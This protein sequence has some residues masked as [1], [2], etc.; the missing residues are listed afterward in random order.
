MT[1]L[2]E[3]W[4]PC[5]EVSATSDKGWGSGNSEVMLFS[6][7]AKRPLAQA[8]AAV[9]T[10]LLPWPEEPSEQRRLQNL[11][12][13]S[14]EG[15]DSAEPA[16]LAEIER[17]YP[18]G[19]SLL[20]PFS[21]RGMIPLEGA[22]LGLQAWG[23]DYLPVA[24][25]A[26]RL[27][28]D[29]PMRDWRLEPDLP[30]LG[31]ERNPL[32][33]RLP[34]D[35]AAFLSE[36]QRSAYEAL[37]FVYPEVDGQR[38][39][40]YLWATAIPCQEC[41]HSFPLVGS[42]MLRRPFPK[43]SDAGQSLHFSGDPDSGELL[44]EIRSGEPTTQPTRVVAHGKS[45]Y[46]SAGKVAVCSHCG[47]V[48][49]KEVHTRL[50][51]DGHG[52]E[53]LL[54][55]ADNDPV[56]QRIFRL[57]SAVDLSGVAL[58]H[59]QLFSLPPVQPS[60]PAVPDEVIPPANTWTIQ[61]Q[62]FGAKT[63]GDLCPPRQNLSSAALTG[64]I[65][66]LARDCLDAGV[67]L[68]YSRALAEYACAVLA[69]RLKFSTRGARLRTPAGGVN[70]SDVFGN[71]ESSWSY[72]YDY[73][74][75]GLADG[76]GTWQSLAKDTV[77]VLKRQFQRAAG[78][79]ATILRGSACSLPF[80][81]ARMHAVVTDPPY[82]AMIDYADASDLYFVWMKR[83]LVDL[84]PEFT[85]TTDPRGLQDKA[86]EMIVKKGNPEG[87]HRTPQ[88]Y[89][90]LITRAFAEARRVVADD[91][92]VTIVFGHG[93]PDVWH[94]LLAA[95]TQAGLVLTGSWPA[96]TEKE[97]AGGGS[98]I[99]TTL[100]LACR[101]APP[102]RKPGRVSEVDAEVRLAIA[103][104]VPRW[105]ASG[106]ALTDQLMA[107]A[108]P[109]MEVVGRY[110]EILDKRG[111]PVLLDRYLPLARR[112]VEEAADIR[113]ESL[114]LETFDSRSRFGLFW[115]RLYERQV[116]P[117]SEA[118]WQ[119]LAFDLEDADTE[120]LLTK[121]EKG[122]RL[123]LGSEVRRD[124]SAESAVIDVAFAL[125]AAG[126]SVAGAAEVLLASGRVEDPYLWAALG[127]LSARLPKADPDGDLWTWLVRNRTGVVLGTKNVEAVRLREDEAAH[128][129]K[130]QQTLFEGGG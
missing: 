45:K 113:I 53:M 38:P 40:G 58:A 100:T 48:H 108:G 26:S 97:K 71:S 64:A 44:V 56:F 82:D 1:R 126:R 87:D 123:A 63:Y 89:D 86:E 18:G 61:G 17:A 25:V 52:K 51:A 95:V 24:C 62:V 94:R 77:S 28:V 93:D 59:E 114:P 117:A 50:V 23:L 102:D 14:M 116:A 90:E 20:D 37:N 15:L 36:V 6:W 21:G 99:V 73:L 7:F 5:Q 39:W 34:S 33:E 74:E 98:N 31:Y 13:R 78:K 122:V 103:D 19:A 4:F 81:D 92:V 104:R 30:I 16:L 46:D 120:G 85:F 49:P 10:S 70:V 107:S 9:I 101:P 121:A 41:G 80:S 22:R 115:V 96:R 128:A 83:A 11:V 127:E 75:T 69:R 91:G 106:L 55:I 79:P 119:R 109:A 110:S 111:E 88:R 2:I 105:D 42:L 129:V 67:S 60:L 125:A 54:A 43:K 84:D 3:R 47:H 12:R 32:D 29:Y 57:P 68:E 130:A 27:L 72:Q 76:P 118:R 65:R 112:F 66:Q 8:R 124:V 35:V